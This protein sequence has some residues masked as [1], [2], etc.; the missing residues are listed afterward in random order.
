MAL[1]QITVRFRRLE[2]AVLIA[3]TKHAKRSLDLEA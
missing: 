2:A 1:E 3:V